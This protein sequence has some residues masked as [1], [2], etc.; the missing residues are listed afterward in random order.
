MKKS[1]FA[2]SEVFFFIKVVDAQIQYAKNE[3]GD[4]LK[5]TIFQSGNSIHA[6]RLQ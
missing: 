3:K 4:I 1:T 5:L 2:E 6:K